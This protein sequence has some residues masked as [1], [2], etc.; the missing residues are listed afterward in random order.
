MGAGQVSFSLYACLQLLLDVPDLKLIFP[1]REK[2]YKVW[3]EKMPSVH[4]VLEEGEEPLMVFAE[5]LS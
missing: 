2:Y 5:H 3:P 1:P 4:Q